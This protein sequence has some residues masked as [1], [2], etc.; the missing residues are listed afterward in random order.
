MFS[1]VLPCLYFSLDVS[2]P[3][4]ICT[5]LK[6]VFTACL[7]ALTEGED[8]VCVLLRYSSDTKECLAWSQGKQRSKTRDRSKR[9][10]RSLPSPY[11]P[12]QQPL[13]GW[14][15]PSSYHTALQN[16][17]LK[18]TLHRNSPLSLQGVCGVSKSIKS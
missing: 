13:P 9:R 8:C 7:A 4:Q 3:L 5:H 14:D 15:V 11:K 6:H 16:L 1:Q 17:H 10:E 18:T 2:K 12:Q